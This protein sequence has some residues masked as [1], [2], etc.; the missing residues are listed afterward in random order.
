MAEMAPLFERTIKAAVATAVEAILPQLEAS[1]A[2]EN[3][4]LSKEIGHLRSALQSQPFELDQ[5]AQYSRREN[6]RLHGVPE[7]ADENT[8]Q[9]SG[10]RHRKR[11]GRPHRRIRQLYQPPPAEISLDAGTPHHRDFY[12]I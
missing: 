1:I 8:G 12:T 11:H 7:T 4:R 3:D 9:R 6:V 10:D 5:L 2:A